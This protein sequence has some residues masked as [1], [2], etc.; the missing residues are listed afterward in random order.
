MMKL[1]KIHDDHKPVE[2]VE[3]ESF[4]SESLD[5][6]DL[7]VVRQV[8]AIDVYVDQNKIAIKLIKIV[9]INDSLDDV[10]VLH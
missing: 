6:D 1:M 7:P 9:R 10:E 3:N 2:H 5:E 4:I 8:S